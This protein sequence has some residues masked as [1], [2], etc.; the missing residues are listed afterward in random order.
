M[1]LSTE[2]LKDV[3]IIYTACLEI[4]TGT[5]LPANSTTENKRKVYTNMPREII[6]KGT[7]AR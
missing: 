2:F 4:K 5:I 3:F 1:L 7:A 6:P